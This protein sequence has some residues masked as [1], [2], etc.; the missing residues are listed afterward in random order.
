SKSHTLLWVACERG[1]RDAAAAGDHQGAAEYA[2]VAGILEE[3]LMAGHRAMLD[4][5]AEHAGY[6]RAGHHG[7]GGGQWVDAPDWISAQFLQHDSRDH[8]PQLHVHGTVANKAVCPV[9]GK[10]RALDYSLF[11]QWRDA[12]GAFADR[13]VEA[14]A[15]RALALLWETSAD[16]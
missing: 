7:G 1:A 9:D 6:A 10:V 3:A 4:F 13:Y 16:G 14:Y 8:D 11:I 15:W 12:A 2:R 5:M